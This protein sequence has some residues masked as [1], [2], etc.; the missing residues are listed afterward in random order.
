MSIS[1]LPW[2]KRELWTF[3]EAACLLCG[4]EPIAGGR[5]EFNEAMKADAGLALVYRELKDAGIK[6]SLVH[7]VPFASSPTTDWRVDPKKCLA[8]A[9]SKGFGVPKV[10]AE[11]SEIFLCQ[12]GLSLTPR[13]LHT[14]SC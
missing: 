14:Q 8:W 5:P 11:L 1:E 3:K 2:S 4:K 12:R 10:L 7:I 9:A 6:G 13:A